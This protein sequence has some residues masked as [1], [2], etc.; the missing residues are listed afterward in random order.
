[1]KYRLTFFLS[2]CFIFL[3]QAIG[4]QNIKVSGKITDENGEPLTGV[5]IIS[6]NTGSGINGAVTDFD[7]GYTITVDAK[8]KLTYTYI[9]YITQ[10]I[11]VNGKSEINVSMVPDLEA[12]DEV[13]ILGY[14]RTKKKNIIGAV[15]TVSGEDLLNTGVTNMSQA[16]QDRLPGVYTEIPSG[17]PGADDAKITIRGVSSF[18]GDNSPLIL[19]DGV[20]ATGGFSQLDPSEIASISILKDA[21]STA[22]Y[23]ARGADGVIIITTN[24]GQEGP[25]RI[26]AGGGVTAKVMSD[27]PKKLSSYEVLTLGQEAIKNSGQ[28]SGLR[29]Q[30]YIDAFLDP[31][32]DQILYPDVDWY[33]VLIRDIGWESNARVNVSGGTE[34]VKYFSSLSVNHVGD[35]LKTEDFGN[36]YYSPEFTYDKINFRTNLDFNITQSTKLSVDISGRSETRKT[37]NTDLGKNDF[38]NLFK[39]IDEATSYFFPVYYPEEFISAHPDPLSLYPGGIRLSGA[40]KENPYQSNPYSAINYGGMRKFKKDVVDI[41]INLNQNLDGITKGLSVSGKFNYSTSFQY[42]KREG[43]NSHLWLYDVLLK[44]WRPQSDQNYN[45]SNPQFH[46]SG[47]ENFDSTLRNLYY[48]FKLNYKRKFGSHNIAATGVFNRTQRDKKIKEL[49]NYSE[50]WVGVLDYDFKEKYLLK[51]SGA[52]NGSERFAPGKRFGFFPGFAVGWNIA[53]EKIVQDNVPWLNSFKVRYNYGVTGSEKNIPRFLFLGGYEA[54]P[55]KFGYAQFGL[56][57]NNEIARWA[58]TKIASPTATWESSYKHNLGFD[59]DL[60]DYD[61]SLGLNFYKERRE[62]ILI[63]LPVPSYYQA[64]LGTKNN[65]GRITLPRVNLGEAKNHGVE[66]EANYS[67]LTASGLKYSFGGHF[68]LADSRIVYRGDRVGTPYYQKNEGK[69]IG[70]LQGYYSNGFINNFEEA[71]NA[72]AVSGG[73]IP[74]YYSYA[75]FNGNGEIEVNDKIPLEGTSQPEIVYAFNGSLSYKGFDLSVRFFGKDGITYQSSNL[76]PNFNTTLLEAKT[77]HLDRWSP[78]NQNAAFPAF[79]HTASSQRYEQRSNKTTVNSAYL[80][81]QNVRLGYNIQSDYLKKLLSIHALKLS[82]TGQN[83]Y[84]WS[85]VPFGD[86]EGGNGVSGGYGQ[87]PLVKRF[88]FGVNIDF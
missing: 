56:P 21:S 29:P 36:G 50:D 81:L 15:S 76:F 6:S 59:V 39:F 49:P 14:T 34:F 58:E 12:L 9:G 23:G 70:W 44:E 77:V 68:T 72:P 54:L 38:G 82:L 64:S 87:Y 4:A 10:E 65:E 73:N 28:Y 41:Q 74:G 63:N 84:T 86:P 61:L 71:I 43:L 26:S 57:I 40:N 22:V 42:Q 20:E 31:D 5:N 62:G 48:E 24:R 18:N 88:I 52:Y 19:I 78:E 55:L 53:K 80:K 75:D 35:I 16:I 85:K 69:P 67:H 13:V 27:I 79:G 7:G 33:D 37:P 66:F 83:L 2:C 32:R 46:T 1:M 17:Q 47:G 8:N 25:A 11:A 45:D 60:L 51:L 3:G 30:S